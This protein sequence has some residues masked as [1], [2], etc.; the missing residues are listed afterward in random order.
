MLALRHHVFFFAVTA[1][2]LLPLA[3]CTYVPATDLPS[4]VAISSILVRLL[5]G[6]AIT[7]LYYALNPQPVPYYLAYAILAPCVALAGAWGGARLAM[8]VVALLFAVA[9]ERLVRAAELPRWA[10]FAAAFLFYGPLFFWGFVATLVGVPFV[11][12]CAAELLLRHREGRGHVFRAALYAALACLGHAMLA[13]PVTLCVLAYGRLS[14]RSRWPLWGGAAVFLIAC[15]ADIAAQSQ[16]SQYETVDSAWHHIKTHLGPFDK[17]AGRA[18]H[19]TFLALLALLQ[20]GG[21]ATPARQFGRIVALGSLVLFVL[22]PPDL[23]IHGQIAWGLNFRFLTLAEAGLLL[24]VAPTPPRWT[25]ALAA[26]ATAAFIGAVGW[27]GWQFDHA[28]GPLQSLL[29]TLPAGSTVQARVAPV[30]FAQAW[31]PPWS[32]PAL[33]LPG[34]PLGLRK[35]PVRWRTHPHP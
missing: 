33:L 29:E 20:R 32:Q 24:G 18:A 21:P 23:R 13:V 25:R 10:V 11:L 5:R 22:C 6:D 16:L 28:T 35:R 8:A 31:P 15:I 26:A 4:H 30:R 1:A 27:L 34:Q 2:M 3:V 17:G 14:P 9:T 19:V 7:Q 12:L